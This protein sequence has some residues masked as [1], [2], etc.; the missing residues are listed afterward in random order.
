[1][2]PNVTAGWSRRRYAQNLLEP[3]AKQPQNSFT[4]RTAVTLGRTQVGTA[5]QFDLS[6][7]DA[8]ATQPR[9]LQQRL[10]LF[11]NAQCCGV[12]FDWQSVM[13]PAIGTVPAHADRRF[14]LSFTLAGVGSFS[15][16]LGAFGIGQGEGSGARRF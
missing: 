3:L 16:V 8:S 5:Y 12:G 2:R 7:F 13:V 4:S 11:Y 9:Q 10:G 15:N 6:L 14:T 1:M